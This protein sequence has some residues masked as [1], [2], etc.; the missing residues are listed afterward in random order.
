MGGVTN[1]GAVRINLQSTAAV[2]TFFLSKN[3]PNC[4]GAVGSDY[5]A[6]FTPN[7]ISSFRYSITWGA[8]NCPSLY[9]L[10][11]DGKY[12]LTRQ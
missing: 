4:D 12:T 7:V 9:K 5:L 1:T 6:T 2:V 3:D 8:P 11:E 10:P